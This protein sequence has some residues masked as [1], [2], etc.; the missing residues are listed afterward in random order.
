[1]SRS[2]VHDGVALTRAEK[3]ELRA[4][5]DHRLALELSEHP[6][7]QPQPH[8]QLVAVQVSEDKEKDLTNVWSQWIGCSY[9][10]PV[11]RGGERVHLAII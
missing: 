3:E 7:S 2:V 6:V 1:V 4:S 11:A 8:D 5:D 9:L 10:V